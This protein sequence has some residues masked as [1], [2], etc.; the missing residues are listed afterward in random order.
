MQLCKIWPSMHIC[1]LKYNKA[2]VLHVGYMQVKAYSFSLQKKKRWWDFLKLFF[3]LNAMKI[4]TRVKN[5]I[6]VCVN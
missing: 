5:A 3:K 2:G 4:V 6:V 1:I